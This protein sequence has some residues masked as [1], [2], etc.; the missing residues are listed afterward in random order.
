LILHFKCVKLP[1]L[2]KVME[3]GVAAAVLVTTGGPFH[4]CQALIRAGGCPSSM[5]SILTK[6]SPPPR[7]IEELRTA[8]EAASAQVTPCQVFYS[9][10]PVHTPNLEKRSI[11]WWFKKKEKKKVCHLRA[12]MCACVGVS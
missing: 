9:R 8:L 11:A 4:D 10:P 12:G 3:F 7:S 5:H 6:K 1:S 2:Y